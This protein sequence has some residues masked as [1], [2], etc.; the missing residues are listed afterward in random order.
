M[1]GQSVGALK[2]HPF[3]ALPFLSP[4]EVAFSMGS[5]SA[6]TKDSTS[7]DSGY[8]N[9]IQQAWALPP[10]PPTHTQY[11][12]TPSG[13]KRWKQASP[14]QP[15]VPDGTALLFGERLPP[16]PHTPIPFFH[17]LPFTAFHLL[18]DRQA[19]RPSVKALP[20]PLPGSMWR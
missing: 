19:G 6:Y 2:G 20:P 18:P 7:L 15:F 8:S 4:S 12:H 5:S 13:K 3:L 14:L 11:T 1:K 10:P 16:P 17:L 9:A